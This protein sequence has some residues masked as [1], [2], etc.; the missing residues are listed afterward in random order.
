MS[1]D[2]KQHIHIVFGWMVEIKWQ[3]G[4][5][6]QQLSTQVATLTNMVA[7]L[8]NQQ[9]AIIQATHSKTLPV[10]TQDLSQAQLP[11]TSIPSQVP[12]STQGQLS[13]SRKGKMSSC[14]SCSQQGLENCNHCFVCGD[15]GHR[16]V[17]CLKR[18][19]QQGNR[20]LSLLR[21]NQK[22][23]PQFQSHPVTSRRKH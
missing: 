8:M 7:V 19:R 17:G 6:I 20:S 2:R 23:V 1:P 13:L 12:S 22:P 10:H 11:P 16:A 3:T 21:N 15:P 14:T 18:A 9:T 5:K 4:K